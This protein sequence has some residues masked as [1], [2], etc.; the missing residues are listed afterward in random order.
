MRITLLL[1][2]GLFLIPVVSARRGPNGGCGQNE[3]RKVCGTRCEPTCE[4]PNPLCTRACEPNVCQCRDG[5][6]RDATNKCI[7]ANSCPN[8]PGGGGGSGGSGSGGAGGKCGENEERKVCGSPCE[9]SCREQNPVGSPRPSRFQVCAARCIP[10][11]CQCRSGFFRNDEN[12]CVRKKA[13]RGSGSGGGGSGGSGGSGSGGSG[14]PVMCGPHEEWAECSTCEPTCTNK[15]PVSAL[16]YRVSLFLIH[17]NAKKTIFWSSMH[18]SPRP[19]PVPD[20]LH[21]GSNPAGNGRG[22]LV[23]TSPGMPSGR[24]SPAKLHW[25]DDFAHSSHV[26]SSPSP[27]GDARG[28]VCIRLLAIARQQCTPNNL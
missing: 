4:N 20:H 7:R 2:S 26:I 6:L 17:E 12:K 1:A 24:N 8:R 21:L 15:N 23:C 16:L 10:N 14:P 9:P 27:V 19:S 25:S 22:K 3:E 11:V 5:Y 28:E 13:C 18:I